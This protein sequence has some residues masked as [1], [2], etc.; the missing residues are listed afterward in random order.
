[1]QIV[2]MANAKAQK[3]VRMITLT[4]EMVAMIPA[5]SKLTISA[6][7]MILRPMDLISASAMPTLTQLNGSTTGAPYR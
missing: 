1:M 2:A 3:N 7:L 6:N 5:W 4:T